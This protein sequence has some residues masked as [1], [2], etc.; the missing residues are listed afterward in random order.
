MGLTPV[1]IPLFK[2]IAVSWLAP[3]PAAY[4]C[5]MLTSA[6]AA[7]LGGSELAQFA[8]L[9]IYAVGEATASAARAGGCVDVR[10]G[11]D[12]V[13]VL[14]K[15]IVA[16]GCKRVLHLTGEHHKDTKAEPL[17][18]DRRVVYSAQLVEPPPVLP[19]APIILI[20]SPR[21]AARLAE[22]I[23]ERERITRTVIAISAAAADQ[24]GAGWAGIRIA[25]TPN[26]DGLLARA[27]EACKAM[28]NKAHR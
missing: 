9:P 12:N 2:V 1:T 25:A 22:V 19:S 11:D 23:P 10:S 18:I 20:H 17:M 27:A 3:N 6:Q 24:A 8:H 14:L 16:D 5:V 28:Q 15:Q 13:K 21:A 4:D 26:D 7:R